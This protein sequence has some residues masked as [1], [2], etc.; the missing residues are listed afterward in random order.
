LRIV[1]VRLDCVEAP[2][3]MQEMH[4]WL[5][6]QRIAPSRFSSTEIGGCLIVATEFPVDAAAEAFASRFTGRIR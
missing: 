6:E 4:L 1:E 5:N 3:V 2:A